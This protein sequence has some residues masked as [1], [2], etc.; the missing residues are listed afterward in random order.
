MGCEGGGWKDDARLFRENNGR[1]LSECRSEYMIR[2]FQAT[3]RDVYLPEYNLQELLIAYNLHGVSF[4]GSDSRIASNP[5]FDEMRERHPWLVHEKVPTWFQTDA[6]RGWIRVV[7]YWLRRNTETYKYGSLKP[8]SVLPV[9]ERRIVVG[10]KTKG[11]KNAAMPFGGCF[12]KISNLADDSTCSFWSREV[13]MLKNP[14]AAG[15][16]KW[17]LQWDDE[18]AWVRLTEKI[19][20]LMA[21][22]TESYVLWWDDGLEIKK[23]DEDALLVI[24]DLR[25]LKEACLTLRRRSPSERCIS[26]NLTRTLM[27]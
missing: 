8:L 21:L 3:P 4:Q 10:D 9:V 26:L 25:S 19:S 12:L 18:A 23:E 7:V 15:S 5:I 24:K 16:N 2:G 13:L 22:D 6:L 14:M 11:C 27:L 1:P 17:D 20:L